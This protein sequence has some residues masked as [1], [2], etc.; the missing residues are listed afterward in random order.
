MA[1]GFYR[2]LTIDHTKCGSANST[3]FT[4]LVAGTYS[5]LAT[6]GNGGKVQNA[7]GYD[8]AFFSDS[9]LTTQL[10]HETVAY[11]ATTGAVEYEVKVPTLTYATDA[12]IYI[13]Y[14]DSGVSTSQADPTNAWDTYYKGVY[15]LPDGTTLTAND[16]TASPANG[17]LTNTPTAIT[18][19]IGGAARFVHAS[20]QYINLG[21]PS[22]LQI[23]SNLTLAAWIR[24]TDQYQNGQIVSKDKDSGGR[25]Y[26]LDTAG[27]DIRFA[28]NGGSDLTTAA[29][30]LTANTWYY[31]VGVYTP[32]S[33]SKLYIN[34]SVTTNGGNGPSSINSA[35]ANVL[36]GRR[37]Y[38]SF[39]QSWDGDID[40]VRIS[41]TSRSADWVTAQYNNQND[42]STFYSVG[43]ETSNGGTAYTMAADAGS[44]AL[45][46]T[47]ATLR[48]G[49]VVAASAGSYT[50][51]GT[52]AALRATR[53][54]TA[55]AGSYALAGTAA[56]LRAARTVA[57][58]S[59]AYTITGAAAGLAIGYRVGAA[60]GSYTLTGTAA[61]LRAA[62][63]VT[64]GAGSYSLTGT[65]AALRL[66]RA[67][68]AAGGSYTLTGADAALIYSGAGASTYTLTADAGSY[69]LTGTNAA[70]R[71]A[72]A[73]I[74]ASGAYTV[75][76]AS[77]ALRVARVVTAGAGAYTLT[78]AS[79]ALRADRVVVAG[80]GTY[81]ITGS[82]A[83]L[84]V[85]RRLVAG[86]GAYVVTGT[87]AGLVWSGTVQTQLVLDILARATRQ[88][89]LT[90]EASR[91]SDI[92]VYTDPLEIT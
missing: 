91:V 2:A 38:A 22:K 24:T 40:E 70:L 27:G 15:H 34:G 39:E 56:S 54:V 1:Y 62:R 61:A 42:P 48:V 75:T 71:R 21:N 58:A 44:Y 11:N 6:V 84:R 20:D 16:S 8:V 51:T 4:V 53:S 12:V 50:L 30:A 63:T 57:A 9:A 89:D 13:A 41:A 7:S 3:D 64:A 33:P 35:S 32:S 69:A 47:A 17:T 86:S 10:K 52:T 82:S 76:G 46:G 59:G 55:G 73:L 77:S 67:I 29:G 66:A 37:E 36:I 49:R 43:S 92:T 88:T 79:A 23:T 78:G 14:G 85:A 81:A 31:V 60:A 72:L 19:K 80:G 65:D 45:T 74:A 5:W 68:V 18:G 83:A 25:A 28:I 90:A 87:A 26:A